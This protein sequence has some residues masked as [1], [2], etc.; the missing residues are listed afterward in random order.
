MVPSS[1]GY[2]LVQVVDV[3]VDVR[4]MA[5]QKERSWKQFPLNESAA[6]QPGI[7]GGALTSDAKKD[8]TYK[9]ETMGCQMNIADSERIEGQLQ[10]LGIRPL[11]PEEEAK[12]NA[13]LVVLNTCSIRDHAE[14]KVYS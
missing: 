6:K 2:H 11:R 9:V 14:Q 12:V 5:S 4:K 8:L 3:M 10:D 13:D 7:L 1:R